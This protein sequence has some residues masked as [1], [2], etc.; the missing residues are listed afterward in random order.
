MDLQK[1]FDKFE[2]Q[3]A[4]SAKLGVSNVAAYFRDEILNN[5]SDEQAEIEMVHL[6][7]LY[8]SVIADRK[9]SDYKVKRHIEYSNIDHLFMEA[10]AEK[11]LGDLRKWA[12]Y[13][14]MRKAIKAKYP[15]G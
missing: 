5:P 13:I 2:D 9:E 11:E 7:T 1:R 10:F 6:E 12:E 14:N 4:L 3:Q 8:E 15:K